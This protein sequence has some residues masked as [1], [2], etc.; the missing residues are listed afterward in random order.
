[1]SIWRVFSTKIPPKLKG[2]QI[3]KKDRL[4]ITLAQIFSPVVG[5]G[6]TVLA[7]FLL[8]HFFEMIKLSLEWPL[9]NWEILIFLTTALVALSAGC[10]V[11][12]LFRV[13]E[14]KVVER[15]VKRRAEK[16]FKEF[17]EKGP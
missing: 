11:Y 4:L 9:T 17:L 8:I 16:S 15:S 2:L 6:I 5:L 1:M 7:A 14:Y 3:P 10:A 13:L 12:G